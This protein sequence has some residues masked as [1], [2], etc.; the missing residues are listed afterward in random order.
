LTD[1]IFLLVPKLAIREYITLIP[2]S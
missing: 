2:M 1:I